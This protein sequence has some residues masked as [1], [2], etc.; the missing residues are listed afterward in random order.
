MAVR[1]TLRLHL[2]F[3]LYQKAFIELKTGYASAVSLVFFIIILLI[4]L[5]QFVSRKNGSITR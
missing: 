4:T 5:F 2:W 1:V 3:I